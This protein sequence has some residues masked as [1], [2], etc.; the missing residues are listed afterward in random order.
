MRHLK[1]LL[2]NDR[3]ATA[4]EYGVIAMLIAVA[5]AG[6]MLSLGEE[7]ETTY[8][9]VSSEYAGANTAAGGE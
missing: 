6:I 4:V 5:C 9:T 8:N 3:G 1:T 7:V 2:A